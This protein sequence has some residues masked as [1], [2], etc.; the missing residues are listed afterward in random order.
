MHPALRTFADE[1]RETLVRVLAYFGG[2]LVLS[3]LSAEL[4]GHPAPPLRLSRT[5]PAEWIDVHR[6]HAA[7]SADFTEIE[8]PSRY[9][10][11]RHVN[12]YGR[13]D[14]MAFGAPGDD[15]AIAEIEIYRPGAESAHFDAPSMEIA[16]RTAEIDGE[17]FSATGM[18]DTKF[19][20]VS[21]VDFF[22]HHGEAPRRCLGFVRAF[23]DPRLQIAGWFCNSGI[24]I[25][26]RSAI[27]CAL[28]RLTLLS[29]GS[30]PKIGAIFAQAELNRTF[31]G[32][33]DPILAAT[34][35]RALDW[36]DARKDPKLRGRLAA[37]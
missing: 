6:P 35:K 1:A 19:G 21:L 31:C 14:I 8:S 37:R 12:F 30:E 26:Q 10:I 3:M 17:R 34:P 2:I 20:A 5:A 33:N 13:K 29:A 32:L 18:L 22:A 27:A 9:A 11:R 25:V 23:D 15:G 7:F 4:I 16:R 36:I 28:D 24:E